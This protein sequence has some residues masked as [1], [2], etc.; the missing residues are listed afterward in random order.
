MASLLCSAF[1]WPLAN[2]TIWIVTALWYSGLVF[3][4]ASVATATQQ[5]ITLSRLTCLPDHDVRIRDMLGYQKRP[6]TIEEARPRSR[7]RNVYLPRFGITFIV[8]I[9]VMM[10]RFGIYFFLVGLGVLLGH[11]A[12]EHG[13]VFSSETKVRRNVTSFIENQS[14]CLQIGTD[15]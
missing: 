13:N 4:I 12:W 15:G 9:P 2:N 7:P 8:Q 6:G 1:T 5:S 11:T 14:V 10:L 3:I